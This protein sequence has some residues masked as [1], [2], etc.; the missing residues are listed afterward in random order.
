MSGTEREAPA[1]RPAP[2]LVARLANGW[3]AALLTAL[4][5]AAVL[6]KHAIT[7]I[8]VLLAAGLLAAA[9]V[10]RR[11]PP[12]DP[13][14]VLLVASLLAWAGLGLLL[15]PESCAHCWERW[16]Q[17][18]GA[19]LLFLPLAGGGLARAAGLRCEPLF[20]ALA[21]GVG[22]GL[23]LLLVEL[24][25]DAPVYRLVSGRGD[26]PAV[27]LS[28]FNRGAILLILL[29]VPVAGWLAVTG[30]KRLAWGVGAVALLVIGN[31]ESQA[32]QLTA[33]TALG[34]VLIAA[35]AGSRLR[36]LALGLAGLLA[37][38]ALASPVVL[39]DLH[40][41]RGET[42]VA[43]SIEHRLEIWDHAADKALTAPLTGWGFAGYR[44]LPLD[45]PNAADYRISEHAEAHPHNAALQLWVE[46]GLVGLL[47]WLAVIVALAGRLDRLPRPVR[48]FALAALG[49]GLL[50]LLVSLGLWQAT[51]LAMLAVTSFAILALADLA[52]EQDR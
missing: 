25:F 11:W 10:R 18:V 1:A 3:A 9:V 44:T 34:L 28:R 33:L 43:I 32:A 46:T 27:A 20:R 31:G 14:T 30:R 8:V 50:P 24:A 6:Q 51:T 22:L 21:L 52:R 12:V 29:A 40:E 5:V 7:L 23:V 35:A 38:G 45:T 13:W 39:G 49:A 26:D 17:T 47:L 48:P 42:T 16:G 36:T 4:P 41:R 2:Q 19:A 15:R 37:V